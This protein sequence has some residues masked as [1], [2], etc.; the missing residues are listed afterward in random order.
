MQQ[1]D[2]ISDMTSVRPYLLRAFYEWIVDNGYT[3]HLLVDATRKDARIPRQHVQDGKIVLNVS[4]SAVRNL[5]MGNDWV[6][7]SARF[8]GAPFNITVPVEGV[9]AIYTRENGQGMVFQTETA[10]TPPPSLA[11]ADTDTPPGDDEEEAE[12]PP[13]P[14]P[15]RKG[16]PNLKVVK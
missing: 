12:A 13:P 5:D 15:P 9:L 16:R 4:P 1:D 10:G 3:P 11:L 6:M 8:G 14:K 2:E 7:F